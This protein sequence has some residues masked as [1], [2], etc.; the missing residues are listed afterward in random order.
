MA[1]NQIRSGSL[2]AAK[3]VP[4]VS[5]VCRRQAGHWNS[6]RDVTSLWRGSPQTG[7]SKPLGQRQRNR[8]SRQAAS[9][10]NWRSN[11]GSLSPFWN[12]SEL[13]ATD[14]LNTVHLGQNCVHLSFMA[15][16]NTLKIRLFGKFW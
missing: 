12:C 5:E 13:R 10:P 9:V 15:G 6:R 16:L 14:I 7:H 11:S 4:A 8:A 1:R 3:M 2:V